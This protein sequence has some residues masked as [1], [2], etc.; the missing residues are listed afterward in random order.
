MQNTSKRKPKGDIHF[1]FPLNEE[2]KEAKHIILNNVI[3]ILKGS[4]GTGKAQDLDSLVITPTGISR[5]GDIKPGDHVISEK[6]L[7]VKILEIFPQGIKDIFQITFSDGSTVNCCE[8]HLWDVISRDNLHRKL[9]RNGIKNINYKKYNTLTL[10]E[11]IKKGIKQGKRDKWFIPQQDIT[12]F[13]YQDISID[14]YILGCLLGDGCLTGLTP[15]LVSEDQEIIDYFENWCKQQNLILYYKPS[16]NKTGKRI[17]YSITSKK[18]QEITEYNTLTLNLRKYNIMGKDS[19]SKFIPKE[20]LYNSEE[21]RLNL[22]Q[23][24]MDTD[25]WIQINKF[26]TGK[27]H[28]GQP[29]FCTV[30]K[31]LK[32]DFIFLIQ[33]LGGVCY[34][35]ENQGKYKAKGEKEYKYTAVNYRICINLPNK[36]RDKIFKLSRKLERITEQKQI[37]NR[38]ISKIELLKKDEAVC[39]L[40]DSDEHLYLTNNFIVTHNS[41]LAS[42]VALD[43]LF[44]KEVEKIIV[45]RPAVTSGED[46]GYL[47]GSKDEKMSVF[48]APVYD[49]MFRAYGKEKIQKCIQEGEIEVIPVGFMRGRNMS[50]CVVI[51][52]EA[53]N[54]T[55]NQMELL[56]GRLC[57][58][59]KMIICG[60]SSQIDLKDRKQSGFDF[61]CKHFKDISGI[62]VITLKTNHR[63]PIVEEILKTYIDYHS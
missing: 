48:T 3:T 17:Q 28:S 32:D 16:L 50:N 10:K 7:P 63:H 21:I 62:S 30:S 35:T 8:D 29:Y 38:S 4:A 52:D 47:P 31:Q 15:G 59:S 40:V 51:V 45:T 58:G 49:N 60:D 33:S 54:V 12:Q 14:P 41:A 18:N 46:I 53:Q 44:K 19:F 55:H 5:I 42:V 37:L 57:K 56:L 1:N 39:I 20:Y 34:V 2:Q 26:R 25:G 9:N 6:G 23:G 43:L 11:I 13:D 22:L 61:I 36:I 27:G 24:L